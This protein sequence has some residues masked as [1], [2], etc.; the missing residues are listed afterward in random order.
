MSGA[1]NNLL[2]I[3]A[4]D[5]FELLIIVLVIV[6][7]VISWIVKSVRDQTERR[8]QERRRLER[9]RE[10]PTQP[11]RPPRRP[12]P[13]RPV[14]AAPP[15]AQRRPTATPT[16][17]RPVPRRPQPRPPQP[18]PEPV[19]S[20][21]VVVQVP[22][23]ARRLTP[24]PPRTSRPAPPRHD[25]DEHAAALASGAEEHTQHLAGR[26]RA[27]RAGFGRR[28]VVEVADELGRQSVEVDL[29]IATLRQAVILSEIIRPPVGLRT[30]GEADAPWSPRFG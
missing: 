18:R 21:P 25:P 10:A 3:D 4:G 16:T 6:G 28:P 27:M 9:E 17:A 11:R 14:R 1:V 7:S 13:R 30:P 8:E 15:V 19:A 22:G 24:T 5:L 20:E 23:H 26:Y 12:Q 29:S 2:A